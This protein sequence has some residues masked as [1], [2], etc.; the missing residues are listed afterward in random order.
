M[1]PC[2]VN[3]FLISFGN[4]QEI[5][6]KAFPV[7]SDC[8]TAIDSKLKQVTEQVGAGIKVVCVT[9][10]TC[11]PWSSIPLSRPRTTL[12]VSPVSTVPSSFPVYTNNLYT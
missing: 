2:M 10:Y 4:K 11:K 3:I 7:Y 5:F 8:A 6:R 1:V 9:V 12:F